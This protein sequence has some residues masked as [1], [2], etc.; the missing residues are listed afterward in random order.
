MRRAGRAALPRQRIATG[1]RQYDLVFLDP[2]YRLADAPRAPRC[3]R[4]CRAVLAPGAAGGRRERP[5]G[6]ARRSTCPSQTNAAT[7]TPSS[8]SMAPDHRI[9][10][11]PGSYDPIT[12][13][14]HRRDLARRRDVRRADRRRRQRLGAQ[15]Q[16]AVHRRGADRLHRAR[17][18]ASRQRPRRAVRR[19]SSSTSRASAGPRRSSRDCARSRTSSTS[20]R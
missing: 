13:R 14:P 5:P 12:Q 2:P 10:V 16:V 3:R 18:G 15:E 6:A 7:A 9:A 20:W 8:A 19:R 11:C 17:D 1:A 4:R